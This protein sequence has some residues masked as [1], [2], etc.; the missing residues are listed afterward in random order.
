MKIESASLDSATVIAL[1]TA[2][3]LQQISVDGLK[4]I[5]GFE[6][7]ATLPDQVILSEKIESGIQVAIKQARL[8]FSSGNQ[9]GFTSGRLIAAITNIVKQLPKSKVL[10]VGTN[11]LLRFRVAGVE[12]AGRHIADHFLANAKEIESKLGKPLMASATRLV[13][14]DKANYWDMRIHPIDLGKSLFGTQGH[15][16]LSTDL[17]IGD[18]PAHLEPRFANELKEIERFL[19]AL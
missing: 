18:L 6:A 9:E 16:H 11:Y 5:P 7:V 19:G 15:V 17:A 10:A 3:E 13:W 4:T 1:T 14:G 8:E 2:I 12:D